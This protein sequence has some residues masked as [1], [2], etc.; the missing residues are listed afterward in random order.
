[1]FRFE[2]F[3]SGS[4]GNMYYLESDEGAILID[5]GVGIRKTRKYFREY[6]I[7]LC[8]IKG[9]LV[10]HCHMDH[11]RSLG[12]LNQKD[13]LPIYL[14]KPTHMGI[15]E[16]PA[17]KKCPVSERIFYIEKQRP[18]HLAGFTICAF[19]VPHDSRDNVGYFISYQGTTFCL[20][21]DCGVITD[22]IDSYIAN[23]DYLVLESNYDSEMLEQGPYPKKLKQR[24]S[25]GTGHLANLL[26]AHAI[27]R[28]QHHLKHIWLCH[29][30]ENNNTPEHA[31]STIKET[32]DLTRHDCIEALDRIKPSKLFELK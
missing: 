14:T 11:V 13:G 20:V 5:A 26:A 25:N 9:I 30:S 19:E 23:A 21:T 24:I 1:M 2:S 29:L 15:N 31:L 3:G 18:F 10:T 16:N 22:T 28:H 12:I 27:V 4:S 6:G 32:L 8:N 17:I 7:K